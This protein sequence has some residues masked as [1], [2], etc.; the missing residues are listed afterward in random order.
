VVNL[1][2]SVGTRYKGLLFS[3][4]RRSGR[5]RFLASYTLAKA[6]NYAND[7]QIPFS[8]GPIDPDDL[9]RE[10]GASPND[11]RHRFTFA[12]SFELPAG[13]RA[14]PLFTWSTGVPMDILMPD[15]STRVPTLERNAGGRRFGSAGELN[16]YL[17]QLNAG[18]GVAGTLLPLVGGDAR[19]SDG[20]S[21]FDLRVSKILAAG[22][23]RTLEAIVEVFNLFN[24]T[25]ILGVST[26]NYSGYANVLA[27][28]SED[29]SSPGYLTSSSFGKPVTT[30]GGV[31]G[32]GGPRAFQLGVRVQF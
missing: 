30:A 25:N 15:A 10:F 5:H 32:S 2:S 12:G 8:S 27:R 24:V 28:D 6:E 23:A 18:G 11:R 14:A 17:S 13:F 9:E 31:F 22:G 16:S 29:P 3:L 1:E 20:F 7:D 4:E 21:S 26:R 19:F